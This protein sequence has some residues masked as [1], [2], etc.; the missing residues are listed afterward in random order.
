[1]SVCVCVCVFL[2]HIPDVEKYAVLFLRLQ[3]FY[4]LRVRVHLDGTD[5]MTTRP[6][7]QQ[8]SQSTPKA[9][10]AAVES[11]TR[12]APSLSTPAGSARVLPTG[13]PPST[14]AAAK[15]KGKDKEPKYEQRKAA[16]D[17]D[18]DTLLTFFL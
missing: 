6:C 8:P 3:P 5:R 2:S 18:K 15:G 10:K 16:S 12:G 7:S 14:S 13:T 1:M 4:P 17:V 11:S 9:G